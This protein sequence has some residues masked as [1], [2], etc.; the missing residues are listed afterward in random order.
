MKAKFGIFNLNLLLYLSINGREYWNYDYQKR[1]NKHGTIFS[2][3][4]CP[5]NFPSLVGEDEKKIWQPHSK[6]LSSDI[7]WEQYACRL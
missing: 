2:I 7:E 5:S 3:A 4:I 6:I 1:S